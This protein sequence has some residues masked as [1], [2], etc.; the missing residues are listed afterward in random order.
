MT[1][2]AQV[3]DALEEVGLLL[4]LLGE[5]PFKSRAYDNAARL[6]RNLDRDLDELVRTGQLSKIKGIGEGLA[7]KIATLV[8]TGRLPY[9]EALRAQVPPGLRQWLRIPGLGPKKAR[10]IHITLGISNLDELE[11][12]CRAGKVR[13]LPGFGETTEQKILEGIARL[14]EHAGRF[15]QPA[16]RREAARLIERIRRVPGLA[17]AEVA[18]SVRRC[19]ETSKDID[20][21]AVARD[22]EAVMDAFAHAPGVAEVTGRGPTKCSVRLDTGPS[23]DLRVVPEVSFP[24]AW[25]YFTGSKAHNIALRSRAQR[26]GFKLNEYALTRE[27]D[28]RT[29]PCASEEEVYETLDLAWIP[30]ELREDQGEIEAAER[31]ALPELIRIEDL[32]G[33]LHVHSAWSDGTATIAE[34]AEAARAMGMTYLGLCD[35][36][37][38]AAYAG[39]LTVEKLREQHA[40]VDALNRRY[41]GAFRVLK[42]A[43]V[44]IL[45]D[46]SLDYPDEVLASLDLVVAS[47]H[48]RF[49]LSAEEQT[50]RILKALENPHVDVLGHVTGRLLL[51]RDPYPLDLHCVLDAAARRG[52]AVEIN[53]HPQRLDL[54]WR[55]LRYGLARGMKTSINPDAHD[56]AGLRDVEYGIGIARKGWCTPDDVINAWPLGRFLRHIAER[57]RDAG[58]IQASAAVRAAPPTGP[59]PEPR[60][61]RS[62]SRPRA[63][64]ARAR[65]GG[66]GGRPA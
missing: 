57:R 24:F 37:P 29:L 28:E 61:S 1:D 53:A 14:K 17:R 30:P 3:A 2:R 26:L 47:V 44:D 7:E 22:S 25:M 58:A 51:T 38:T 27:A 35:H 36:S 40:E 6:L 63:P 60:E 15:L 41:E 39:G 50:A 20:I 32:K 8:K 66:R 55:E 31:R 43:E 34:M 48:S 12:A 33:I 52:V 56:T 62:G 11:A 65:K 4:E 45:P 5:N 46:G 42:G 19:L 59:G 54:D 16:V 23:A 18:G 10:A 13:E 9:L 64:R 21:V 49:N